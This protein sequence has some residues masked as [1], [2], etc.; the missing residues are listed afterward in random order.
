MDQAL[1]SILYTCNDVI[2]SGIIH[3]IEDADIALNIKGKAEVVDTVFFDDGIGDSGI[4]TSLADLFKL[5]VHDVGAAAGNIEIRLH[6]PGDEGSETADLTAGAQAEKIARSLI[7]ADLGHIFR[8]KFP[9]I[10]GE[11]EIKCAVKITGKDFFHD[12]FLSFFI[13]S[14]QMQVR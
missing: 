8:R 5:R 6:K 3:F 2:F 1:G 13:I 14:S 11:V 7:F 12:Q 10:F 4:D 9:V